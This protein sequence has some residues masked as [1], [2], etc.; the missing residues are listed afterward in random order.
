MCLILSTTRSGSRLD[1][2]QLRTRVT[3][4]VAEGRP[5]AFRMARE[6]VGFIWEHHSSGRHPNTTPMTMT[7][8]LLIIGVGL[9]THSHATTAR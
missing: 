4:Q 8:G 5:D 1:V 2:N 9:L 6:E 3:A 7:W